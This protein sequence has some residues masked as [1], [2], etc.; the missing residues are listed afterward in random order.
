[1][2]SSVITQKN[3]QGIGSLSTVNAMVFK[4]SLLA[5]RKT[6]ALW[7]QVII[8]YYCHLDS[9]TLHVKAAVL[10]EESATQS[11]RPR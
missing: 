8:I 7:Q 5:S 6:R 11:L 9:S 2:C 1:M 10:L 3:I 4:C